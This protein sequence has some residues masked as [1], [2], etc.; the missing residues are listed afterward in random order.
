FTDLG[1]DYNG[2]LDGH[3][4][5]SLLAEFSKEKYRSGVHVIHVKT[6]KGKGYQPAEKGNAT[7]WHAPGKFDVS[8]GER[9][10][11][12]EFLPA[13]YQEVFGETLLELA[14]EDQRVV[15]IT[16]AMGS[17]SGMMNFAK[18]FPNRFFDVGIA[19]QHAVTF[20]AGLATKGMIPF[21]SIYSTFLQRG[22]DQVIHDVALQNLHVVFCVD[23][24]GLAGSDGATHQGAFDLAFLNPIPNLTILAP[25]NELQ[26]RDM[27]KAATE[28]NGPVVIRYP[29]GRGVYLDWKQPF[30]SIEI[31]KGRKLRQG[32][33]V[34]VLSIG[35]TGN[36]VHEVIVKGA[37][38]SHYDMRSLKPLDHELLLE[39]FST[40][41]HLIT[42]E[43][44]SLIGGFASSVLSWKNENG[45]QHKV[46]SLGIPDQFI[47]H[48]TQDEL[49]EQCGF[50][51]AALDQL[52][53]RL[54][55]V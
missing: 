19:E 5:S 30:R 27:M 23:R 26:L 43:D 8:T 52:I 4:I 3:D 47:E 1:I 46:H 49:Y 2:P 38:I 7:T 51:S 31:G 24:A 37:D 44:G 35:H 40:H 54:K 50:N 53:A 41:D 32:N 39:A 18:E 6:E 36:F 33:N 20:S 45:F 34:A 15:G 12:S 29:R 10:T 13:K 21:C 16:P 22:F 42:I 48:G 11:N 28:M 14:R 25:M 17:G 55:P 9:E